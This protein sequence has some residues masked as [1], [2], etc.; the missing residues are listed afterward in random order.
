[1][2]DVYAVDLDGECARVN[3]QP[4]SAEEVG[5]LIDRL[6]QV[7]SIMLSKKADDPIAMDVFSA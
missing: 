6:E 2:W 7:V 4:L 3:D 5:L 1:M